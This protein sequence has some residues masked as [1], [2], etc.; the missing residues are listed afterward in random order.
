MIDAKSFVP[1]ELTDPDSTH[2]S[3]QKFNEHPSFGFNSTD[4][5]PTMVRLDTLTFIFIWKY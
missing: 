5:P 3:V 1:R 4:R 2:G